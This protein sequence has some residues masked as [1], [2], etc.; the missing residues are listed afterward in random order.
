[1][2]KHTAKAAI[3]LLLPYMEDGVKTIMTGSEFY[4]VDSAG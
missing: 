4:G 1:V 2:P 3:R